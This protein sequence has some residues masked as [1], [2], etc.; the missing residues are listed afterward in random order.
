MVQVGWKLLPATLL[1][2]TMVWLPTTIVNSQQPQPERVGLTADA[3]QQ[4]A[5]FQSAKARRTPAQRKISSHL[6]H[7]ATIRRGDPVVGSVRASV[8]L[9]REGRTEVDLRADVTPEVLGAIAAAGGAVVN[10]QPAYRTIRASIPLT[11]IETIASLPDVSSIRS[12]DRMMTNQR[13]AARVLDQPVT[14]KDN[15]TEGDVAHR[16]AL[17]RSLYGVSGSGVVIGV[18]SDGVSSLA[19]R[20]ATG[21]LPSV[22]VLPGQAGSGD[23]GTAMLEIVHDLAPGSPLMFAS[24]LGG[25]A[26][27]ATNVQQLCAAGAKVIVDDIFYP[28]EAV[29]QDGIVAQGVNAA[30]G[31]G[32][33]YFSSAG[34]SGNLDDGTSGVWEGDFAAAASSPPGVIGTAHAFSGGSSSN[35]LTTDPP[36]GITLQWSDALGGSANDY[37]LYLFNSTLDVIYDV[38][39]DVQDGD[40]DP[41][42]FIDSTF[43]NDATNRVVVVLANGSSRY[44]HLNTHRGRLAIATSG[45]ISGHAAAANAFAVAAINVGTAGG[46][47]FTGGATNPVEFFSSD[48]PRRIF[49]GAGGAPITPGNFSATG[50]QLLQKP[51][52]AA[53]DCVTTA[54]PGF[55]PF[56]GT[57]AAAPHAAAVAALM[58]QAAGGPSSL[59]RAQIRAAIDARSLDI[60]APGVDRDSGSGIMDALGVIGRV[61]PP[62]TDPVLSA[63]STV[64][65]EIHL[66]ELRA[67]VDAQRV[68]CHLVPFA[69]TDPSLAA[70]LTLIKA[71]HIAELRT[72]LSSAYT[73]CGV[74]PPTYSDTNLAGVAVKAVHFNELRNAVV[75]LE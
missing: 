41:V 1:V 13:V 23:E 33:V 24:A 2:I 4:I 7:A 64:V 48:G 11:Q 20:Q 57:S 18:I 40:D 5:A 21:D 17:A 49:Y 59:T 6:L 73:A 56:C 66:R 32:C 44:L 51:D 37:D 62:F 14:N 47:A 26:Q 45:Q 30:V 75:A 28:G 65:R 74:S 55:S 53:A 19:A 12:A 63:G 46:G 67:R 10:S 50:G 68:R 8:V 15:S 25:Q 3:I 60:E 43:F 27:F 38:S 31:S 22:T 29:F 69:W 71:V 58:L 36:F 61:H 42:E 39:N 70:A 52:V 34:N 72:A 35:Q 54:T 9:D 16:A